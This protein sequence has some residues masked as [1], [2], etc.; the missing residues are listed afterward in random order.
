MLQTEDPD[1]L[2]NTIMICG[3]LTGH[4][5]VHQFFQ[6]LQFVAGGPEE[7]RLVQD[8]HKSAPVWSSQMFPLPAL[9]NGKSGLM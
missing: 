2:V 5:S 3:S 6:D 1:K 4:N 8:V 9:L 7:E